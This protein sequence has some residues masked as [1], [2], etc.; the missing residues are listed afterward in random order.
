MQIQLQPLQATPEYIKSVGKKVKKWTELQNRLAKFLINEGG[1]CANKQLVA[2][3]LE[4]SYTDAYNPLVF[5][6]LLT[7]AQHLD[8][9]S[10]MIVPGRD[11]FPRS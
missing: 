6:I 1:R 2:L 10:E 9:L 5:I 8:D 11:C 4:I 7:P 3:I